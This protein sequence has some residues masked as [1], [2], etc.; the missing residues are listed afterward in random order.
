MKI[1]FF[2]TP[3]LAQIVLSRLIASDFKPDIVVTQPDKKTGRGQILGSSAVKQTA[4][5][6][7]LPVIENLSD[8]PEFDLGILVAFG[9]IL[10][11]KTLAIPKYG[12]INIHPSLLPKYRGPSPIQNAILAGEEKT[13]VT[14]IKLDEQVDHGPI[15]GNREVAIAPN[16]NHQTLIKKLGDA[17]AELLVDL[18]PEF[19]EG[20]IQ[21]VEQNHETATFTKQI[22]KQDGLIDLLNPPDPQTLDRMIRAYFPWP[23]AWTEIESRIENRESRKLK[24]KLLPV[25]DNQPSTMNHQPFLIQPEGKRPITLKEFQNGYPQYR[26]LIEKLLA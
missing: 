21:P 12:I 9:K 16:D 20:K 3:R 4:L 10:P 22:S 26:A 6:N 17:G 11:E 7:N 5:Q 23:T 19:L 18:L 1:A 8:L 13:G 14:I 15:L 2:G 24:I 25:T